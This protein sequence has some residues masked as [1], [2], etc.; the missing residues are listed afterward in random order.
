MLET[1]LAVLRRRLGRPAVPGEHRHLALLRRELAE[2]F[3]GARREFSVPHFAPGSPFEERV[4]TALR[5][6]PFG[7]TRSYAGLAREIGQPKAARSV[8]Q[9]NGRNRIAILIPCHRVVNDDGRPGGYGG[10][11]W[12]KRRLL[13]LEKAALERVAQPRSQ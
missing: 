10:G 3:A 2:Y 5:G 1:Q 8:G 7:E 12:R 4:W 9:A 6:I 11:V 13:D